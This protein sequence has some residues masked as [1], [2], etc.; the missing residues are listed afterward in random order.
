[1]NVDLHRYDVS[2]L[3]NNYGPIFPDGNLRFSVANTLRS[4]F[5][6]RFGLFGSGYS[7]GAPV[8]QPSQA[9]EVYN[10]SVCTLSISH[11]NSVSHY[12]SDRLLHCLASGR[13][14]ITWY[15][16]GFESY[17]IEGKEI[18]VARSADD[19]VDIVNYC[20]T[21]PDIAKQIGMNGYQRALKEHTFTSRVMELLHM[22]NLIHLV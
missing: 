3:G 22:T 9:N 10:N 13:P 18:F 21:N 11:F 2:F 19:I 20:K 7:P 15:F 14:T 16:P 17:F 1:M 5:G 12:F 6:S 4:H 8:A